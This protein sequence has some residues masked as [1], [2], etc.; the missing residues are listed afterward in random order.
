MWR[1][2]Y[3]AQRIRCAL[4]QSGWFRRLSASLK[5]L[6][7]VPTAL[8]RHP[9]R[10]GRARLSFRRSR[11]PKKDSGTSKSRVSRASPA[12]G[13]DWQD[14]ERLAVVVDA[15]LDADGQGIDHGRR[16]VDC[17]EGLWVG[18]SPQCGGR[19]H[20]RAAGASD[21][22]SVRECEGL[23]ANRRGPPTACASDA[24]RWFSGRKRV[25]RY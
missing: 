16:F 10:K 19:V 14:H 9:A 6:T 25:Y 12:R 8:N 1:F 2:L 18:Q 7:R 21:R 15:V 5:W 11:K 3:R 20:T 23:D 17:T 24:A 13:C 22:L 4:A